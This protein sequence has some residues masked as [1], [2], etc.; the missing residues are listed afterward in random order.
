MSLEAWIAYCIACI[1]ISISPGAGAVNTMSNGIQYGVRHSVPA[2][3]GLQLGYSLQFV[4]VGL[5]LGTLLANSNQLFEIIKWLGV[6]YLV[7]LGIQKWRQ[8]VLKID[9]TDK[10]ENR[11]QQKRF[12][13]ATL[14]N[15]TNPKATLFLVAF[16]PQFLNPTEPQLPQL[17]LMTLTAISVDIVVMLGYATLAQSIS[18]LLKEDRFQKQLNRLFGL[19]FIAA[20]ALMASYRKSA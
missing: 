5:G 13:Q 17:A 6:A 3:L 8:P 14:V 10:N 19:L 16:L 7:W 11:S 4:I 15:L 9:H 2:I 12:W 20:A 1:V 18:L